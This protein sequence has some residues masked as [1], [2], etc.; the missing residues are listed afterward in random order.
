[1]LA[2]SLLAMSTS[3]VEGAATLSRLSQKERAGVGGSEGSLVRSGTWRE[4]A[5]SEEERLDV[6]RDM[7]WRAFSKVQSGAVG[8]LIC[9]RDFLTDRKRD[10]LGN[11]VSM[12]ETKPGKSDLFLSDVCE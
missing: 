6:A 11:L 3:M 2:R 1:M 5:D 9:E 8:E 4:G 12:R 10:R 7:P